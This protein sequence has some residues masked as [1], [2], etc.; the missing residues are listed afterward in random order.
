MDGCLSNDDLNNKYISLKAI[1][2]RGNS[3]E[4]ASQNGLINYLNKN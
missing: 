4:Q 1:I 2:S 3:L